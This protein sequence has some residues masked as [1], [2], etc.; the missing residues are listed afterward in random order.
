MSAR[1]KLSG[2]MSG[3]YFVD[4]VF[5]DGRVVL[6]PDT[7]AAAMRERVGVTA[8]TEQELDAFLER[9][10]SVMLPPEDEG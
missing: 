2:E 8:V 1:V 3:D 10:G 7:S 9:Y 4:Q 6:R 5:D